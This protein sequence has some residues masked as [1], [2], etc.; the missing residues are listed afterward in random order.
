M[1]YN[2]P[3]RYQPYEIRPPPV[4]IAPEVNPYLYRPT[5]API[6]PSSRDF[7]SFMQAEVAPRYRMSDP[8]DQ[9][10]E[11]LQRL[12]Q[13]GRVPSKDKFRRMACNVSMLS[14]SFT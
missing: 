5:Y 13:S 2:G 4:R 14:Y 12:E 3:E 8:S 9:G 6:T 11:L 1:F 7:A 10:E